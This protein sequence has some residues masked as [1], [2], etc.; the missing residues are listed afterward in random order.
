MEADESN[1]FNFD[2]FIEVD[3]NEDNDDEREV[4][5]ITYQDISC[6]LAHCVC[7]SS[8]KFL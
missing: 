5:F 8:R 2:E 3:Y 6:T 1:E 4:K 7:I